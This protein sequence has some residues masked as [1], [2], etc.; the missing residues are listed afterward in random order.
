MLCGT[1]RFG[2]LGHSIAIVAEIMKGTRPRKPEDAA[3]LGFT[4]K[5]WKIVE[6]CWLADK[7]ARPT[8]PAVL[9]CLREAALSWDDRWEMV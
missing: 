6:R 5:L 2:D 9:F 3:S 1:V 4:D 7:S 8:L